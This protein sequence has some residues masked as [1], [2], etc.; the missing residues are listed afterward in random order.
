MGV[1][2]WGN[3][4]AKILARAVGRNLNKINHEH[5]LSTDDH[6]GNGKPVMLS[7][8]LHLKFSA[9]KSQ[10]GNPNETKTV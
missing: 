7:K 8:T 2:F 9:L 1:E 6:I 3:W 4:S 10:I 5:E